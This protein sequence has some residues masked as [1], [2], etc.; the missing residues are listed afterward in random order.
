MKITKEKEQF[1]PITIVI[2]S[3]EELTVLLSKMEIG[4]FHNVRLN[5]IADEFHA[6][7]KALS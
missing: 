6:K 1:R 7:L 2:E 5:N 4:V 3:Q